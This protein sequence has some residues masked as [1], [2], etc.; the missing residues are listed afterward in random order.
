M[1]DRF[2]WGA[3]SRISPEAPVPVVEVTNEEDRPGGAGNVIFNLVSLEAKV[4]A[5]GIVG[6]DTAGERL[7]RDFE[8]RGVSPEGI[9]LDPT[10]PTSLKTR[11]VAGHQHVV[12]FDKESKVPISQDFESRLLGVLESIIN[13]VDAVVISDYGKGLITPRLVSWLVAAVKKTGADIFV[14][15]K[16]ENMRLYKNVTCVTPNTT[17]AFL[18]M[19][20]LPKTDNDSVE[21]IGKKIM[22]ALR[23]RQAIITRGPQGMTLFNLN[24]RGR[25]EFRH[26]PTVAREVFDVT[27]AGDTVVA[28]YALSRVA[29]ASPVEAV[30]LANMAAGIVVGKVG[31][32]TVSRAELQEASR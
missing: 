16:P 10:R 17:E 1:M 25:P 13:R 26:I 6:M 31:T 4:Y 20:Q 24:G 27:G 2:I 3:V 9:L 21:A 14:D 18:G 28:S 15:P 12:R 29:G 19:G 5:G 7:V 30:H 23:L 32:A 22:S 11:V 8:H